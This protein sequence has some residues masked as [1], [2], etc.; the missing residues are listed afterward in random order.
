MISI[1]Y[2]YY[3]LNRSFFR[4]YTKIVD[5]Y[6][7]LTKFDDNDWELLLWSWGILFLIRYNLGVLSNNLRYFNFIIKILKKF[8]L[9]K[10][11]ISI[12]ITFEFLYWF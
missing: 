10:K 3:K 8:I 9:T 4:D 6:V 12:W 2:Y 11:I 7:L 1:W 5:L